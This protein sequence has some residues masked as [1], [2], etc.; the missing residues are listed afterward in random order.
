MMKIITVSQSYTK[1]CN[2]FTEFLVSR[3][4]AI[5]LC[6]SCLLMPLFTLSAVFAGTLAIVYPVA[7]LYG[8]L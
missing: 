8:L 7:W 1:K 5:F 4:P 3:H 6:F 2:D